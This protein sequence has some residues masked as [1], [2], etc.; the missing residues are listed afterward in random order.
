MTPSNENANKWPELSYARD[1]ETFET[2]HLWSQI[3]GKVRLALTPWLNHSWHVPLY[4]GARGL[5]TSLI[6]HSVAGFDLEFDFISGTL[7]LRTSA[8]ATDSLALQSGSIASFHAD[9]LKMLDTNGVAVKIHG[10][11]NEIPDAV[12]FAED[13]ALRRYDPDAARRLWQALLSIDAVFK[14]FRTGFL[15]KS[16]PVHF[17]WGSFDLAMA[18]FSGRPAPEHPGGSPYLPDDVTR[19]AYSHEMFDAGFWPGSPDMPNPSFF[20]YAYPEPPGFRDG[21]KLPDGARFDKE[22]EEYVFPY[23][24]VRTAPDPEQLLLKFLQTTYDLAADTGHWDRA[25]LDSELGKPGVV[26]R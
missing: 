18:F 16:S 20:S 10:A 21:R 5:T 22:L 23:D 25:A 26:R 11:P 24:L 4:L 6:P 7:A 13:V 15:G 2:L 14:R 8:G 1:R 9:L 12:P 3:V 17:F 19:D